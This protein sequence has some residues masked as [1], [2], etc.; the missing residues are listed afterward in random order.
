MVPSFWLF[1][2]LGLSVLCVLNYWEGMGNMKKILLFSCTLLL[3]LISAPVSYCADGFDCIKYLYGTW[4]QARTDNFASFD[5]EG[6]IYNNYSKYGSNYKR[7]GYTGIDSAHIDD[8][9][10]QGSMNLYFADGMACNIIFD[11]AT[12]IRIAWGKTAT[13]SMGDY[14]T[15]HRYSYKTEAQD[16]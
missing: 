5:Y 14:V 15:M 12:T 8:Y 1:L 2:Q 10:H 9:T 13:G 6:R 16:G 4:A 3:L 11:N 7:I